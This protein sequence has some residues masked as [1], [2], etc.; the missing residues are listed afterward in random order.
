MNE[1]MNNVEIKTGKQTKKVMMI[2]QKSVACVC[3][4]VICDMNE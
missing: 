3:V 1:C 2:K 4:C